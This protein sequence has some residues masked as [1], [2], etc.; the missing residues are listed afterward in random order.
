MARVEE[1]SRSYICIGPKLAAARWKA[2]KASAHRINP[3]QMSVGFQSVMFHSRIE[4]IA[5]D[6]D[7]PSCAFGLTGG[8]RIP[9]SAL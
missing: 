8:I 5:S 3:S 9:M 7:R 4:W 2:T 1:A 6:A